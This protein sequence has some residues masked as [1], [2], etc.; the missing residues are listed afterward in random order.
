MRISLLAAC[1]TPAVFF[2]ALA[3]V[4]RSGGP[5]LLPVVVIFG[6]T[7][8]MVQR[9]RQR[10]RVDEVYDLAA[11]DSLCRRVCILPDYGR[12]QDDANPDKFL[13]NDLLDWANAGARYNWQPGTQP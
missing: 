9:G 12:S 10:Q 2:G 11:L 3:W 8:M 4:L 1:V 5:L 6:A 13:L 7:S